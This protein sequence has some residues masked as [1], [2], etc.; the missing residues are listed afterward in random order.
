MYSTNSHLF[1]VLALL[2]KLYIYIS[3]FDPVWSP[4]FR[5]FLGTDC[6]FV[7]STTKRAEKMGGDRGIEPTGERDYNCGP[8]AEENKKATEGRDGKKEPREKGN[9]KDST[10]GGGHLP[11]AT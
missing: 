4:P 7:V 9:L 11:L 8:E 2:C 6:S 10:A 5:H 3:P 1:L